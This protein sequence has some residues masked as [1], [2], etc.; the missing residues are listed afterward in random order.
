[1][2]LAGTDRYLARSRKVEPDAYFE[3]VASPYGRITCS[4]PSWELVSLE[5]IAKLSR[6]T[7]RCCPRQHHRPSEARRLIH[8]R[9][10]FHTPY[11]RHLVTHHQSLGSPR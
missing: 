2:K 6:V 10:P 4:L 7:T 8:D 5:C 3:L 9:P 11:Q 1:M